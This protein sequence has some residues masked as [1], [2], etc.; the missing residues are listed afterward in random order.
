M[1]ITNQFHL[2]LWPK[3]AQCAFLT[4]P[5]GLTTKVLLSA[6]HKD[7][8]REISYMRPTSYGLRVSLS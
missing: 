8:D 4:I 7:E 6:V 2:G 5:H 1:T 3:I